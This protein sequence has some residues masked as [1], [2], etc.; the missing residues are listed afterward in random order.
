MSW[1]EVNVYH[2]TAL[3]LR[4]AVAVL[5]AIICIFSLESQWWTASAFFVVYLSCY[6][7][8]RGERL[9]CLKQGEPEL[10]VYA[11]KHWIRTNITFVL[12]I[13]LIVAYEWWMCSFG[14]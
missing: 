1:R 8:Y 10:I 14:V 11:K 4:I 6:F 3:I 12:L 7:R 5:L 13:A 9:Q 2:K